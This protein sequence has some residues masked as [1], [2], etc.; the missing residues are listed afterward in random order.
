MRHST[1]VE[2]AARNGT[3]LPERLVEEPDV[4][5]HLGWA[6]FQRLYDIARNVLRTPEDLQRLVRELAEDE[7][8]A[9]SGWVEVQ[10]TPTSYARICGDIVTAVECILDALASATRDTA[11]GMGLVIAADRTRPDWEAMTLARLA[12]RYTGRGVVGFGLSNDERRGPPAEFARAFAIAR[13]AGL[14]A[15]PHAGELRGPDAV[16]EALLHLHADRLGH[17]VRAAEDPALLREL[18]DRGITCEVCPVSNSALG[19]VGAD[20]DHPL[21]AMIDA[22]VPVALG[23]DDPLLFGA[24]LV[25]AYAYA[26]DHV[27]ADPAMLADIAATSVR[28]S[29]AP[30]EIR[31]RLDSGIEAWRARV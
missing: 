27:G 14:L 22:G 23:A 5:A 12:A 24:H 26:V 6:R 18:V 7:G 31:A 11:V 21:K 13:R 1:L 2:L 20:V 4:T 29:A 17:G 8:A 30:D 19:V 9:G 28:A 25:D 10:M 3:H 15:L 16:R